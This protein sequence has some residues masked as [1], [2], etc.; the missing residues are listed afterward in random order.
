MGNRTPK[1]QGT[2]KK[3]TRTAEAA[4]PTISVPLQTR[5]AALDRIVG[6]K[7]SM[8]AA[9]FDKNVAQ[10]VQ[11]M[12]KDFGEDARKAITERGITITEP[13]AA[14]A[15]PATT[16]APA[17][18]KP[19]PTSNAT[20]PVESSD[21]LPPVTA[22]PARPSNE[23]LMAFVKEKKIPP[24]KLATMSD[25]EILAAYAA[26]NDK[27][28]A[29]A[30]AT[31]PVTTAPAATTALP[32]AVA[33]A[34]APV[35]RT[36]ADLSPEEMMALKAHFGDDV[37]NGMKGD[38]LERTLTEAIEW[39]KK[40]GITYGTV[41]EGDA[42]VKDGPNKDA[43]AAAAADDGAAPVDF[44]TANAQYQQMRA[45]QMGGAR[46]VP[47]PPRARS[48]LAGLTEVAPPL[49]PA[50]IS[51]RNLERYRE[52]TGRTGETPVVAQ[53][54][55]PV[56]PVDPLAG[57]TTPLDGSQADATTV[58]PATPADGTSATNWLGAALMDLTPTKDAFPVSVRES[59]APGLEVNLAQYPPALPAERKVPPLV[60]DPAVLT[61]QNAVRVEMGPELKPT[62]KEVIPEG[63]I[64]VSALSPEA[65]IRE[66]KAAEEAAAEKPKPAPSLTERLGMD[67][68]MD[69]GDTALAKGAYRA[70][71]TIAKYGTRIGGAILAGYAANEARKYFFP[72][73]QQEDPFSEENMKK[74]RE[75]LLSPDNPF[76]QPK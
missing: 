13:A 45:Q 9:N 44:A 61:D 5:L 47:R 46:M 58:T 54:P 37:I 62:P 60:V 65:R 12:I 16:A 7:G 67:P 73:E 64:E 24:E 11:E 42:G 71:P 23:E 69:F 48:P 36:A 18:E 6:I 76:A 40:K 3:R 22:T 70:I 51:A 35:G 25:E 19:A 63:P 15:V 14:A 30:A 8:D 66:M 39:Q 53:E 29:A 2:V 33:E 21:S 68:P 20:T 4:A 55:Q 38:I 59:Q 34:V 28:A 17:A 31:A 72:G 57:L 26:R 41:T 32:G 75:G 43:V 74:V 49:D 27:P 52:R 56:V 1:P 50:A 10:L